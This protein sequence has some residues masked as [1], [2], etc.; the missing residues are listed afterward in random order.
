MGGV[1]PSSVATMGVSEEK[2]F[3]AFNY[4]QLGAPKLSPSNAAYGRIT[5]QANSP[6]EMQFGLKF[7]F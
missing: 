5:S 1:I 3:N 2:L 6:R 7:Q 4:V